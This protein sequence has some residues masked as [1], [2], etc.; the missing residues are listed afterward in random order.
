MYESLTAVFDNGFRLNFV[1]KYRSG[2]ERPTICPRQLILHRA[3]PKPF[4]FVR[5]EIHRTLVMN[6]TE[7]QR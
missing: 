4:D 7:P 2:L 6:I 5:A 3:G 1:L